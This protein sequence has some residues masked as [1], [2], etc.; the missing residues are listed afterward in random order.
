MLLS[1]RRLLTC[2]LI[3]IGGTLLTW[4]ASTGQLLSVAKAAADPAAGQPV[5][6]DSAAKNDDATDAKKTFFREKVLPL[7]ESRCFECHGPDSEKKGDLNLSSRASALAG[8]E[9][10]AAIV[11]DKPAKRYCN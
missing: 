6:A 8:G 3:C 5:K 11:P 7:L 4:I 10:G 1:N 2:C 9:S